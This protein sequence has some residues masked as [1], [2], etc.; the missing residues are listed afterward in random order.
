MLL[1]RPGGEAEISSIGKINNMLLLKL[2]ND[3]PKFHVLSGAP[4]DWSVSDKTLKFI[5]A[6]AE[7]I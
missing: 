1:E 4:V 5:Y 2:I 3:K 6:I 7:K